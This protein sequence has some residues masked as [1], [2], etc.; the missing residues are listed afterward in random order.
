MPIFYD[1][2]E[3][4]DIDIN[5]NAARFYIIHLGGGCLSFAQQRKT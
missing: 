1:P 3:W 5:D 4:D 2:I